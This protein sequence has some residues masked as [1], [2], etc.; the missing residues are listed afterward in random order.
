MDVL[1]INDNAPQFSRAVVP[2]EISESAAVGARIPLDT[3][4]DP[5]VGENG[6]RTYALEAPGDAPF[7][8]D[9]LARPDGAKYAELVVLRELDRE[10]R[11]GYELRYDCKRNEPVTKIISR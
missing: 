9:V 8:V 6:L 11:A 2:I 7:R 10:T 4:S 3:A 1:D 5:D